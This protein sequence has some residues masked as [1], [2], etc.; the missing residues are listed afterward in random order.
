MSDIPPSKFSIPE[1]PYELMSK[2]FL[3]CDAK[4]LVRVQATSHLWKDTLNS[5]EF[6]K[7]IAAVWRSK[8]CSLFGHFCYK[9]QTRRSL[10]W[11]IRMSSETGQRFPSALPFVVGNKGWF[12]IVGIDNGVFC[13]RLS[14]TRDVSNLVIWNS[15]SRRQFV[16][17]DPITGIA[18]ESTFLFSFLYYQNTINH[19]IVA[20]FLER[21][22]QTRCVFTVYD[23]SS[24]RWIARVP[25]PSYV[26]KLD[27]AYVILNGVTYW[28][29]WSHDQDAETRPYIIS[30][31]S[32]TLTFKQ[33]PLP[34]EALTT[35]HSL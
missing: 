10:D 25:C 27:P 13:F 16:L 11:V 5:Y 33:I 1:L 22:R 24:R 15:M 30:F 8:G 2:I 9:E 3:F 12:D 19:S 14:K 29:T 23:S 35:C 4:T 17:D 20:I 18:D 26:R 32:L 7:E 31:S 34:D 28:V 21:R 6:V